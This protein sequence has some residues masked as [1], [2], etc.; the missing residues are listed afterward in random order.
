MPEQLPLVE[1]IREAWINHLSS[2][3]LIAAGIIVVHGV[4]VLLSGAGDLL[5]D[6]SPSDRRGVY[7]SAAI[8][9]SLLASFTGVAIGQLGSAKGSRAK[10]L[11]SGAPLELARNWTSIFRW[12]LFAALLAVFG[13]L[14]DPS[15]HTDAVLPVVAR[16]LFEAGLV[17]AVIKFLR[18]GSLFR[19]VME[20]TSRDAIDDDDDKKH[21]APIISERWNRAS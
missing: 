2:D 18:A 4:L 11:K 6:A 13:L 14:V 5:G 10:A 17:T 21:A 19:D 12:G 16:W 7:T 20:I 3:L 8:V 9:V 1:R 15:T